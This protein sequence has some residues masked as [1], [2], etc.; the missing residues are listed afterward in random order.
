[1]TGIP[2]QILGEPEVIAEFEALLAATDGVDIERV[3]E[4][5]AAAAGANFALETV[6]LIIAIASGL[7]FDKPIVPSIL[8]IFKRHKNAKVVM[9]TPTGKI[10]LEGKL[11]EEQVEAAL[12]SLARG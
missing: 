7:F 12:R 6:A 5:D 3:E 11:T 4:V 1:M 8:N 10:T 2:L 9:E